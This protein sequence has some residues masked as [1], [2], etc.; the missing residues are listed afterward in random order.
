MSPDS[1][2]PETSRTSRHYG[3]EGLKG[4]P[5]FFT[6]IMPRGKFY[7][8]AIS[9]NRGKFFSVWVKRFNLYIDRYIYL[10]IHTHSYN[11]YNNITQITKPCSGRSQLTSKDI[12]PHT[13]YYT[14]TDVD[15]GLFIKPNETSLPLRPALLVCCQTTCCHT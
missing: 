13:Y 7:L 2:P 9:N 1:G 3:I 4:C 5:H 6:P 10:A 14:H 12:L 8:S 11:K 15:F